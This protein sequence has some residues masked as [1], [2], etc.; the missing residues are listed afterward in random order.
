ME[1]FKTKIKKEGTQSNIV[2]IK[3]IYLVLDDLL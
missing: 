2:S 1:A 3:F